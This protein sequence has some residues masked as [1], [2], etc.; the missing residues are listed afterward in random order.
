MAE[1]KGA[2]VRQAAF[3]MAAQLICS[4]VGLLYR[5]PLHL[6]MGDVGDG[7][8]TYAYEWYTIILLISSYSIPM[9]IS[10]VMAE[11]LALGQYKNAQKVFHGSLLYVLFVGGIGASVAFFGAPLFLTATPDAVLALRILAPTILLS[12]FLGCLRGYFQA[13]NNMMPTA[14]SRVIEQILNAI[15]SVFAAWLLTR[16]YLGHENLTGK[17]GAAGGTIGTGSGVAIGIV[18]MLIVYM[19]NRTGYLS[20]ISEDATRKTESYP[21]VFKVIFLMVT[22][23][24]FATCIYNATAIVDQNIFSYSMMARGAD[25]MEIS[26]QYAL[27]GYR[28]KPIINIPIALSSATSTALIPAVATAMASNNK[29]DARDKINECMRLSTFLAIPAAVGLCVLSYPVIRILYPTGDVKGAAMLLSLGSVSVIFYSLSTVTN[30]VLQGLGHPSVPVRNAATALAINAAAAFVSVRYLGMGATGVLLA[31]VLYA[32]T[33]MFLNARALRKILGYRH[34]VR[35]LFFVPLRAALAMGVVVGLIYWVPSKLFPNIF[36]RYI[37]SAALTMVAVLFGVVVY[38]VLY[39]KSTGMTD[40]DIR[41]LPMGT[42]VL[43][44]LKVFHLR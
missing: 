30:G 11:R 34:N 3:L 7:Y 31:T 6:I 27:F 23:I 25:A 8:Y 5:S 28:F 24:I 17:Y 22:P 9:A 40:D 36:G 33:V 19:K 44:M 2:V 1:K 26:R 21:D 13:R 29:Q 16:P 4:V 18:F 15:M 38:T 10:K 41:R 39:T 20:K 37:I 35:R 14:V 12:G 43:W 42:K 32:Y